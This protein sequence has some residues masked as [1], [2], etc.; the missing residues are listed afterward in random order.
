M[1]KNWTEI[2]HEIHYATKD[3]WDDRRI[4]YLSKLVAA[5]TQAEADARAE[6]WIGVGIISYAQ[7][8]IIKWQEEN[9]YETFEE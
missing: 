5:Y 8:A 4:S 6:G 1:L 3:K 2:S 7:A 9:P